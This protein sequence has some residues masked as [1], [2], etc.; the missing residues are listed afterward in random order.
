MSSQPTALGRTPVVPARRSRLALW[1]GI[2]G[3][4]KELWLAH[5][6]ASTALLLL[7]LVGN[8]RTGIYVISTGRLVDALTSPQ[9]TAAGRPVLFWLVLFLLAR[10][11]EE[12]YWVLHPTLFAYLRDHGTYR[13]Q[14]KVLRRAAA[15]PLVRFDDS[16]FFDALQRASSGMG[17]RLVGL[18]GDIVG[19][20]QQF[21]MIAS[22]A[23]SL[24]VVH[25]LLL[26]LLIAGIL[27]GIWLHARVAT[28]LYEFQR[29]QTTADRIR[30]YLQRLVTGKAAAAELRLFGLHDYLLGYWRQLRVARRQGLL[31]TETRRAVHNGAAEVFSTA[32]YGGGL[33][34]VAFL[35]L[36]GQLSVGDY[37][38]VTTGALWFQ[39]MLGGSI[40]AVRS[41]AE[42]AQF[43]GDLFE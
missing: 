10:A 31:A 26:P 16:T 37:V 18:F 39:M 25:P 40:V 35:I 33:I 36:R 24:Y 11:V 8:A 6:V 4:L 9:G 5:P 27:P 30:G 12:F 15:A 2:C 14:D 42:E 29:S 41:L 43:L 38:A 23:V 21:L 32:A 19:N 7:M 20:L 13:I 28:A 22:V 1:R 17:G 3:L 34:L